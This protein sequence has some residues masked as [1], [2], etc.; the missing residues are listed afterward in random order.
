M[1]KFALSAKYTESTEIGEGEC[2]I[3]FAPANVM[4]VRRYS[5]GEQVKETKLCLKCEALNTKQ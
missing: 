1:L 4:E 5:I 2:A 3:C